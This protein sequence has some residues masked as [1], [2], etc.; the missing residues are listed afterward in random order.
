MLMFCLVKHCESPTKAHSILCDVLRDEEHDDEEDNDKVEDEDVGAY[1][2]PAKVHAIQTA[3]RQPLGECYP[4]SD[5]PCSCPR[6]NFA[7][8]PEQIPLPATR[9]NIPAPEAWITD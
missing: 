2:I 6:R 9:S 1:E 3:D 7:D 8:P 4:E 5:L